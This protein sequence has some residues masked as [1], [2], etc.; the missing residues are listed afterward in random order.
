MNSQPN[1]NTAIVFGVTREL[2][3][4]VGSVLLDLVRVKKSK[5]FDVHIFH[6]GISKRNRRAI[7]K[8]LEVHLISYKSKVSRKTKIVPS[9]RQFTPMV[10]AKYECLRLL[11]S[12]ETVLWLDCDVIIQS[13]IDEIFDFPNSDMVFVSGG[14]PIGGQFV[15]PIDRYDMVSDSMSAGIIVF[16]RNK[17]SNLQ[18]TYC[19]QQTEKFNTNLVMPEQGI[20]DLMIQDFGLNCVR[21]ASEVYA[22]HP[23]S[24][25]RGL[26]KIIHAYGQPKFWNG[27]HDQHWERN[28]EIWKSYGGAPYRDWVWIR[29][30]RR[31]A[32]YIG[33]RLIIKIT[34]VRS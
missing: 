6:D 15:K 16:N 4:A 19:L 2:A 30:A 10:F 33:N 13:N 21:L 18:Y 7:Q 12:Y 28:A 32:K 24:S 14:R 31:K 1:C 27:R 3:P 29:R 34:K 5:N 22:C 8:I 17:L 25:N 26:A 9:V 11:E 23:L 20:F